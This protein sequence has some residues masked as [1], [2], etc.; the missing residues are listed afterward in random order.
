MSDFTLSIAY[1]IS[2]IPS[3]SLFTNKMMWTQKFPLKIFMFDWKFLHNMLSLDLA[4]NKFNVHG[5][6]KCVC[7]F[8]PHIESCDYLFIFLKLHF[9]KY[10]II[11]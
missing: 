6:S 10:N 11:S 3:I 2:R 4:C 7:C 8:S 1:Y 5:S 9:G